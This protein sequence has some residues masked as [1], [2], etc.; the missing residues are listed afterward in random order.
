MNARL[1]HLNISWCASKDY[2]GRQV[3]EIEI[4]SV[5]RHRLAYTHTVTHVDKR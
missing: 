3:E 1:E 4:L 5:L 2:F